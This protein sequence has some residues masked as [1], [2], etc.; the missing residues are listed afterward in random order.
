M[1]PVK[2]N[3]MIAYA[4]TFN[5]LSGNA[6]K[7]PDISK[8]VKE[9]VLRILCETS[10]KTSLEI[11]KDEIRVAHPFLSEAL[12]ELERDDLIVIKENFILLT[13]QGQES[14]KNILKKHLDLEDYFERTRSKIEAH[15]AAHILE[16]YISGEVINN[17]KKLSTLKKEGV[18]LT[19][20]ELNKEG[21]ITDITLSDYSLYER[22]VSMGIFLGEK[23]TVT[24]E[25]LHGIVVKTK[26]KKFALDRNV[27]EEIKAVEYEKP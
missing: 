2:G 3:E 1:L 16:H 11:I 4:G 23:I 7:K 17:I 24:N 12:E 20:F 21:M 26:N 18:P 8:I 14:A 13:G 25:I 9:D 5:S 6:A 15:T 10:R 19:K 22:I 27:A